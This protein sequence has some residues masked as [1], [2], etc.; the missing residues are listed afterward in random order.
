MKITKAMVMAAGKG[1]RM[2]PLTDTMPKPMVPFAGKPLIDHVL[3]RLEE[4]GIEE[5]IVNVHHF[6]DMLEAHVTR[7]KSP[8]IVISDERA[9]L[10]DTGG[11]AKKA[12]SL[13]GD[14]PVITFNSDSVWTEGF[15]SNLREL[16]AAFDPGR[17]DALLMIADAART[18]GYVGRGDFTMDPFGALARREPS[19]TAPFMFAGVQIIKP[20]LFA[21]GP[22]GPFSTN[23]IWDRLIEK[24]TLFGH[25][26][27]GVWMHVG[28]PD[29]LAE[30]EAFLRDL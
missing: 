17:M 12:L 4:A 27:G 26:M 24:G 16:I 13:L 1:T 23:L 25:R 6:A 28:A 11:G 9:R 30:A 5:A 22:D 8:R 7:R 29:D 20:A 14:E 18:I 3:D 19:T 15:G 21:E 10:L 2:R